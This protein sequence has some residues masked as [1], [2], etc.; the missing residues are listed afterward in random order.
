MGVPGPWTKGL[1]QLL[2]WVSYPV[3]ILPVIVQMVLNKEF[4]GFQVKVVCS[5]GS[6]DGLSLQGSIAPAWLLFWRAGSISPIPL[7]VAAFAVGFVIGPFHLGPSSVFASVALYS[8]LVAYP[9][10]ISKM[11]RKRYQGFH[12]EVSR[13]Q[14]QIAQAA[15]QSPGP[16]IKP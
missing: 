5:D 11:L 3:L 7:L 12:L 15:A 10:V 16:G 1:I 9:I 2:F 4:R 8:L 14:P 6:I 13:D